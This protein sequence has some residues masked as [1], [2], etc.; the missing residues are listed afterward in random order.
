MDVSEI[1]LQ[2]KHK[3]ILQRGVT[4][5]GKSAGLFN[6]QRRES[7]SVW[8]SGGI[9]NRFPCSGAAGDRSRG[10]MCRRGGRRPSCCFYGLCSQLRKLPQPPAALTVGTVVNLRRCCRVASYRQSQFPHHQPSHLGSHLRRTYFL[11]FQSS[12]HHPDIYTATTQAPLPRHTQPDVLLH[13]CQIKALMA[14]MWL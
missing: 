9:V 8:D 7:S 1:L 4:K 11:S 6:L 5:E 3:K 12:L 14:Q 13:P 2:I 10:E